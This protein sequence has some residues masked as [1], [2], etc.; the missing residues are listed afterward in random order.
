MTGLRED[1]TPDTAQCAH[2]LP[3][4]VSYG[5]LRPGTPESLVW[6][7]L[8]IV[9]LERCPVLLNSVGDSCVHAAS[10]PGEEQDLPFTRHLKEQ[11]SFVLELAA[12]EMLGWL[13]LDS[14][15][16]PVL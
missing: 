14:K 6:N 1:V 8:R 5:G 11:E 2:P 13:K 12:S 16:A 4:K 9:E 7:R 15:P 3:S 10:L